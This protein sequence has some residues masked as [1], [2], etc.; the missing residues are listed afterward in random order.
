[1]RQIYW[2]ELLKDYDCIINYH[3]GKANIVANASSKKIVVEL[4]A[5]FAQLSINKDGSLMVELKVKL[6]LLD[7]I[8]E[9]QVFD[10]KLARNREMI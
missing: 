1:M 3:P 10:T 7:Q 4:R 6:M 5:M 8:R 2:V 9:A